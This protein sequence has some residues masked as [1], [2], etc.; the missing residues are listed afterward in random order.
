MVSSIFGSFLLRSKF[1]FRRNGNLST[2]MRIEEEAKNPEP[3]QIGNQV[4]EAS[5]GPVN[6]PLDE[7]NLSEQIKVRIFL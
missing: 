5:K 6:Q 1:A 2:T 4:Q 7:A 3:T